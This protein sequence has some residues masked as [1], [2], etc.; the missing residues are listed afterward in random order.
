MKSLPNNVT[1][2][3]RTPTFTENTI[4]KGLLAEHTT[5]EGT[6]GLVVVESGSLIYTITEPGFEE[7]VTLSPELR[8]VVVPG[9]RHH[10]RASGAVQ[11]YVE[12]YK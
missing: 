10:V 12:F 4:P 7:E 3:K 6:W 1:P 5:K 9:Q 11:F 2:Y 8:G